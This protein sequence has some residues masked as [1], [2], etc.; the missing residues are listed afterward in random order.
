MADTTKSAVLQPPGDRCWHLLLAL[1]G[2]FDDNLPAPHSE[3]SNADGLGDSAPQ[4]LS[5]PVPAA[6]A[7]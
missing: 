4:T 2:L 3:S 5:H 6:A 1:G 7:A